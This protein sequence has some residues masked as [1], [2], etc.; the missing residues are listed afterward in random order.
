MK[1]KILII[2]DEKNIREGLKKS[3]EMDGFAVNTA[4]NGK[5]GLDLVSTQNYDLV[6]T[7]LKMPEMSGEKFLQKIT[8][9]DGG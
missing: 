8:G 2:D 7:D 4:E 6:I 3:L 1:R 5:N 9:G